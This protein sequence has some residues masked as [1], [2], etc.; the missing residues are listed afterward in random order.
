[1]LSCSYEPGLLPIFYEHH[2][3]LRKGKEYHESNTFKQHLNKRNIPP[4]HKRL[5]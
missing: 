2:I 1:M 3:L 5:I 4:T